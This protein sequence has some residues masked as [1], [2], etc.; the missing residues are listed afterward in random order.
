LDA[1][2]SQP[3]LISIFNQYSLLSEGAVIIENDRVVAAKCVLPVSE[4]E[5]NV[6]IET[7]FRHRAAIEM[8]ESTDAAVLVVSGQTGKISLAL[9]GELLQNMHIEEIDKRLRGYLAI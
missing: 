2:I 3:L 4:V 7:G 6:P 5:E 8:S 9:E 1:V